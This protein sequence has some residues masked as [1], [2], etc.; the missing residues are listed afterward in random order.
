MKKQISL[1]LAALCLAALAACGR[2][3]EIEPTREPFPQFTAADFQGNTLTNEMFGDYDATVINV[4]SNSC[5]PCIEEMPELEAYY[6]DFKEKNINLI[7]IN[8]GAGGSEEEYRQAE[9]ILQE[10][11]VTFTNLVID[12]HSDFYRDFINNITGYPT[13]YL[14]DRQ[15]NTVGAPLIGAVKNQ[16]DKL[17]KRL[18]M[19]TGE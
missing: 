13:T 11:G 10:K 19:I 18:A 4:W 3:D 16:E 8:V 12:P 9:R 2:S 14:V 17:M 7:A 6:Q 1:L 5:G 15:G